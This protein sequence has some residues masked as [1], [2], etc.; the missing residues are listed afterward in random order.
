H[1]TNLGGAN[2]KADYQ[3]RFGHALL[4]GAFR[5]ACRDIASSRSREI[6]P[7]SIIS[8]GAAASPCSSLLF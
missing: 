6:R 5:N 7:E 1:R 4:L 2:I 3:F 8:G